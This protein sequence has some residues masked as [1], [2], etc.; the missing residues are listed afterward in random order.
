M[1]YTWKSIVQ[2]IVPGT[3][4]FKK[5]NLELK[6]FKKL[7]TELHFRT[8]RIK[9]LQ[10]AD[11]HT[12]EV[13]EFFSSPPRPESLWDPPSLLSNGYQGLFPWG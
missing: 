4:N 3:L 2:R 10:A 5:L 8:S 11:L 13:W 1:S 9:E 12:R 7:N 6:K